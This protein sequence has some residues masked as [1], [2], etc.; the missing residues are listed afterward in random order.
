M[1]D[2]CPNPNCEKVRKR[3]EKVERENAELRRRIESLENVVRKLSQRLKMD[4]TNS[5][6]P[7]S[8]DWRGR[9]RGATSERTGR[10]R[11]GQP[12]H[13]GRTRRRFPPS[14]IDHTEPI[15]PDRCGGCRRPLRGKAELV[16]SHQ[17]VEVPIE[18]AEV[19]EYQRFRRTCVCGHATTGELPAGVTR[20]CVGP[21]LQAVVAT[22]TGRYR[23]SRREA[24]DAVAV[25]FGPKAELALGTVVALEARTS[26]ALEDVHREALAAV[27]SAP[28]TNVDET[29]WREA[30]G[31][32]WL[33][34]A[35]TPKLA[36]F[37]IDLNRSRA[38]FER[39]MGGGYR[40]VIGTDRWT[41]YHG[42][43]ATRRALCWAH[44]KR[45]FQ[46][47]VDFGSKEA[48]AIGRAGLRCE[49]QVS[50]LW[51]RYQRGE[52]AHAS[53]RVLL[54]PARS[55]LERAL[56]R[57]RRCSDSKAASLCRDVLKRHTSLWTFARREGV[58]PT[59]NRAERALRKAVLWR[60]GSFGSDS[61]TGS[62]I[63]CKMSPKYSAIPT[64]DEPQM[65][66]SS[67]GWAIIGGY[68]P[69][70]GRFEPQDPRGSQ[71]LP[72]GL[73]FP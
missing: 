70:H 9:V 42:H 22:L 73:S 69:D 2:R 17:V 48:R 40:G 71:R 53:L 47:L 51:R 54:H 31:K 65:G 59:N 30:K 36:V 41:S 24:R 67:R 34:G 23:L 55:K 26:A 68:D 63:Q 1:A 32:A 35:A 62:L 8:T 58:E 25:L 45:N 12:G 19:T 46:A 16:D 49:K 15:I 43:P 50:S 4:S 64:Q 14:Q 29:S 52:L 57:G 56:L 37:H 61:A 5:S 38:A 18:P 27:R 66:Q 60:K 11:G 44:L 20:G 39:L 33:W 13:V 7:P 3:V 28:A 10:A 21:R 72:A 6:L